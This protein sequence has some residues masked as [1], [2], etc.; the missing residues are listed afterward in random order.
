MRAKFDV[1]D[2]VIVAAAYARFAYR[3]RIGHLL[4][5]TSVKVTRVCQVSKT[6]EGE[7]ITCEIDPDRG[8][9][10][11][12]GG[13]NMLDKPSEH[14]LFATDQFRKGEIADNNYS[15]SYRSLV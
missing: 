4:P 5:G 13:V 12:S 10:F 7:F 2:I 1:D 15:A 9:P 3:G 8:H 14:L 11:F 6:F